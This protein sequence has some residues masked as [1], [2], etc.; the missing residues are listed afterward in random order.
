MRIKLEAQ[1][2]EKRKLHEAMIREERE[3]KGLPVAPPTTNQS[4]KLNFAMQQE[5]PLESERNEMLEFEESVSEVTTE[6]DLE[7]LPDELKDFEID[8][9]A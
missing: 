3:A 1:Q 7:P 5:E 9:T 4:G 8:Q 2:A 6:Q